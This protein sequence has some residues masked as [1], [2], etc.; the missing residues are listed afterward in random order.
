MYLCFPSFAAT[1]HEA[2]KEPHWDVS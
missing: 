2:A 1:A